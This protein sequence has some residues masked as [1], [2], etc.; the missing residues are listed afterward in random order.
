LLF[1]SDV[2]VW[3]LTPR[4]HWKLS[5]LS[6]REELGIACVE[7]KFVDIS[8]NTKGEGMALARN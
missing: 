3:G 2:K 8:K 5:D 4:R 7:V 6:A 1:K